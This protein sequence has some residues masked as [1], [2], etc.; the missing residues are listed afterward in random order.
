ME[1]AR[2]ELLSF[3]KAVHI[4]DPSVFAFQPS[5]LMEE[6]EMTEMRHNLIIQRQRLKKGMD[7][8]AYNL[9]Q[10]KHEIEQLVKDYPQYAREIL[11]IVSQY[12]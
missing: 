7:F 2:H 12:E 4:K 10:S 11:A 3:L 1:E 6:S 8:N 5:I 9:E